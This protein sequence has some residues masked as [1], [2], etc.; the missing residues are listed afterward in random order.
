MPE[1]TLD[2]HERLCLFSVCVDRQMPIQD[3]EGGSQRDNTHCTSMANSAMVFSPPIN[4]VS[5]TTPPSETDTPSDKPQQQQSSTDTSVESS[6]VA[7]I[8]DSLDHQGISSQATILILSSWRKSTEEAYSCCWRKW[9]QW[10][11]S[12]GHSSIQAPISAILDFLACQFAEG[13]QYRT[14]NSYRSAISMTHNPIDGVVVG[15]HPLV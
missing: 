10:C 2:E 8:R 1:A 3:T 6:R 5:E 13:K 9:E 12:F 11:A 14:I 4:V 15:K 7:N